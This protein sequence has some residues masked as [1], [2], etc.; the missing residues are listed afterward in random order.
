MDE[1]LAEGWTWG[2]TRNDAAREHPDLIPYDNLSA[3]TREYDRSAAREIPALLAE[4]GL[5]ICR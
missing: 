2:Q 1:R 4:A 3:Q 5:V